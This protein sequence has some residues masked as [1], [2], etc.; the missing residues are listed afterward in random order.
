MGGIGGTRSRL[1]DGQSMI[2]EIVAWL[3]ICPGDERMFEADRRKL[4]RIVVPVLQGM[5]GVYVDAVLMELGTK[6]KAATAFTK[7]DLFARYLAG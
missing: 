1:F 4:D 2:R 3:C 5:D 7:L 6:L